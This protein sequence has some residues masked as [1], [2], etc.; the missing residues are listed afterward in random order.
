MKTGRPINN[1][2]IAKIKKI[3]SITVLVGV[4]LIASSCASKKEEGTVYEYKEKNLTSKITISKSVYK[5]NSLTIYHD[6]FSSENYSVVNIS[7]NNNN[8]HYLR[9]LN[10]DQYAV[11]H[12]TFLYTTRECMENVMDSIEILMVWSDMED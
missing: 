4:M 2:S 10:T 5:D 8:D 9:W 6:G 11:L 12:Y 1:E 7:S 3:L